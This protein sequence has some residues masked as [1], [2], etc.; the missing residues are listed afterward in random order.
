MQAVTNR[1]P[2][3]ARDSHAEPGPYLSLAGAISM[4]LQ[5]I[6]AGATGLCE[7]TAFLASHLRSSSHWL[8]ARP[9]NASAPSQWPIGRLAVSGVHVLF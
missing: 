9:W 1:E 5:P 2:Y 7:H 3:G 6:R 4:A 8:G